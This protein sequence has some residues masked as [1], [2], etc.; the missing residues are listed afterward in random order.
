MVS[1]ELLSPM[2]VM[3]AVSAATMMRGPLPLEH[4]VSY[5]TVT[6]LDG[7]EPIVFDNISSGDAAMSMI[8]ECMST[9]GLLLNNPYKKVKIKKIHVILDQ[10]NVLITISTFIKVRLLLVKLI[11]ANLVMFIRSG[12]GRRLSQCVTRCFDSGSFSMKSSV[13]FGIGQY[14]GQSVGRIGQF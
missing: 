14:S 9:V 6:S 2:M 5:N 13:S 12:A 10:V 8:K 7:L 3:M 11:L 1:H 4:S